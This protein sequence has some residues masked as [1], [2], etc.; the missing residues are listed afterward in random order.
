MLNSVSVLLVNRVCYFEN[1]SMLFH[2]LKVEVYAL[3]E[4]SLTLN[5]CECMFKLAYCSRADLKQHFAFGFLTLFPFVWLN[6][7]KQF[8]AY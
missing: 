5:A 8:M 6:N 2:V 4:R 3:R 1:H 7:G